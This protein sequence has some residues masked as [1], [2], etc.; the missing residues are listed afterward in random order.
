MTATRRCAVA[1]AV[2]L[3]AL[4]GWLPPAPQAVGQDADPAVAATGAVTEPAQPPRPDRTTVWSGTMVLGRKYVVEEGYAL[5]IAPGTVIETENYWDAAIEVKGTLEAVGTREQ[6]IRFLA[7]SPAYWSG[8]TFAGPQARGRIEHCVIENGRRSAITCSGASP[9]VRHNRILISDTYGE[10]WLFCTA[11]AQP[12]I[13]G[14]TIV[15]RD[16]AKRAAA[17]I[18][19]D[20]SAPTIAGNTFE[21]CTVGVYLYGFK[22]GVARPQMRGNVTRQCTLAVFDEQAGPTDGWV[23]AFESDLIKRPVSLMLRPGQG[24]D[25]VTATTDD[26]DGI[27]KRFH[28]SCRN[29]RFLLASEAAGPPAKPDGKQKDAVRSDFRSRPGKACR[30]LTV[31]SGAGLMWLDGCADTK[32]S[33]VLLCRAPTAATARRRWSGGAPSSAGVTFTP[34]PPTSTATASRNSSSPPGDGA[35]ARGRSLCSARRRPAKRSPCSA[36]QSAPGTSSAGNRM[37]VGR[38]PNTACLSASRCRPNPWSS[39]LRRVGPAGS[40][41]WRGTT[42]ARSPG[43][44]AIRAAI[45]KATRS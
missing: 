29:G 9:V 35:R 37:F 23:K 43:G 26:R 14:N 15:P 12:T 18:I 25:V 7:P 40:S 4:V 42:G 44:A 8:I 19:C 31:R 45:G 2:G 20:G 41:S 28:L 22:D 21:R 36:D 34:R 16:E 27:A 38:N 6:P 13:E 17:A 39:S 5:R 30:I 3:A 11:G 24:G 1:L 33:Y 32:P 10:G